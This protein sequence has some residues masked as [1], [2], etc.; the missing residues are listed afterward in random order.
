MLTLLKIQD[1]LSK[2]S[3]GE[4]ELSPVLQE[5]FA[6]LCK[7]AV[8]KQLNSPDRSF[9]IRMSGLG[10]PLCQQILE[11]QGTKEERDYNSVFR[12]LYGDIVEL[13]LMTIMKQAGVNIVSSQE[14]VE[15]KK[16]AV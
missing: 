13:I 14:S 10:R 8:D 3:R 16:G 1:Y 9:K 12:F 15:L 2:A 7:Q 5:E 4:T 11:K 6:E